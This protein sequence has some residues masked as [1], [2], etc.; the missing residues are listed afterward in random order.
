MAFKLLTHEEWCTRMQK[1]LWAKIDV[2]G[3]D[4]CWLWTACTYPDGYGMFMWYTSRAVRAHRV[5]FILSY[6]RDIRNGIYICH[7]CDNRLCC[8]PKHLY[9]CTPAENIIDA[10]KHGRIAIGSR[11]PNAKLTESGVRTIRALYAKGRSYKKIA[12]EFGVASATIGD[13]IRGTSWK[14]IR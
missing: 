1:R 6:K 3:P 12:L 8:N 11:H 9:E 4:D 13:I 14:H 7:T 5:V 10:V 2:R